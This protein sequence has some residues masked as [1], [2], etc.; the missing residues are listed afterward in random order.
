MTTHSVAVGGTV[1]GAVDGDRAGDTDAGSGDALVVA[2]GGDGFIG[3]IAHAVRDSGALFL[4]LSGG[5]GN[6]IVRWFGLDG[7][8][9]RIIA[10][11][12]GMREIAVDVPVVRAAGGSEPRHFLS[13]CTIGFEGAALHH[14][15]ALT[16]RGVH[17]GRW[18]YIAG[19]IVALLGHRSPRFRVRTDCGQRDYTGRVATVCNTGVY[20][21][22][23]WTC[24]GADASDGRLD[25]LTMSDIG[26]PRVLRWFAGALVRIR[27]M[28][29]GVE[30]SRTRSVTIEAPDARPGPITAGS[31]GPTAAPDARHRAATTSGDGAT[32]AVL[33]E[34]GVWADG[35]FV[36]PLPAT[37][38]V[39]PGAASLRMLVR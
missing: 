19:G 28:I 30:Q 24:P 21:G 39:E 34:T 7:A 12:H 10:D 14:A 26:V 29:T 5:R 31:D 3:R 11:L 8:P 2:Y 20:G 9:E 37:V 22:G 17:L 33:P 16:D 23:L 38:E 25:V 4:P 1:S 13:T 18:S 35:E 27:P 15:E 36:G 6:D 32:T